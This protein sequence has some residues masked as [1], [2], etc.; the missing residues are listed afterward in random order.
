MRPAIRSAARSADGANH[1]EAV[2]SR[3]INRSARESGDGSASIAGD[4]EIRTAAARLYAPTRRDFQRAFRLGF[5]AAIGTASAACAPK[6]FDGAKFT[7]CT[8]DPRRED[9]RLFLSGTDGKPYGSLTALAAGLK[10]KGERLMFAM[11]AGMFRQDQSPVGLYVE[12]R[13]QAARG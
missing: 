12:D 13:P 7:V 10:A 3:R 9:I 6:D 5:T 11:N 2:G 1:G 8:F 4:G